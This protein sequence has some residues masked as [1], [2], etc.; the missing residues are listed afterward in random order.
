MV[1]WDASDIIT[2]MQIMAIRRFQ[3]WTMLSINSDISIYNTSI[4][5]P[6]P[7][8][9]SNR[10]GGSQKLL[11]DPKPFFASSYCPSGDRG[12]Q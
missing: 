10:S 3:K 7:W 5:Y 8:R 1:V 4:G 12:K 6:Q 11:L 9:G 2:A